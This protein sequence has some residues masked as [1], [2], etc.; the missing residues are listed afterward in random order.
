MWGPFDSA[1]RRLLNRA[2]DGQESTQQGICRYRDE[3]YLAYHVPYDDVV[4]YNDHHRQVAVTRLLIKSDGSLERIDPANDPGVGT[5]GLTRL[6]LDAFAARREAAEFQVRY[7]VEGEPGLSGEYAMNMKNGGYL[8]F[9]NM[10]FGTGARAFRAEM[11]RITREPGD[12]LLEIRLDRSSGPRIG[13]LIL[14]GDRAV[15]TYSVLT[16]RLERPVHGVHDLFL[17][18]RDRAGTA[19]GPLVA[20][21]WFAFDRR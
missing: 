2:L 5:P 11:S 9:S 17:M 19:Q 1:P 16:T 8:Q 13:S 20:L 7:G 21:T 3:W 12:V 6:T 4:P 14:G 18:A 15:S 10:D